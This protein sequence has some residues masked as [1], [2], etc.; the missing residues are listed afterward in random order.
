ME[1]NWYAVEQQVRDRLNEARTAAR[2]RALT[3]RLAPTA[4]RPNSVGTTLMRVARWVWARAMPL[5]RELSGARARGGA[6]TERRESAARARTPQV[7]RGHPTS[8]QAVD[9]KRTVDRLNVLLRP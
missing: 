2:I 8:D 3:Q 6:A 4:R 9:V 1:E 7:P 5:P